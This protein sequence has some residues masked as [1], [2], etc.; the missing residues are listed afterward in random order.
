MS[1]PVKQSRVH[2]VETPEGTVTHID[3]TST[4]A[5]SDILEQ[6]RI[7]CLRPNG[8]VRCQEIANGTATDLLV[9]YTVGSEQGRDSYTLRYTDMTD[10]V[11]VAYVNEFGVA[12]KDCILFTKESVIAHVLGNSAVGWQKNGYPVMMLLIDAAAA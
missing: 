5:V 9:D 7:T 12:V 3:C 6:V 2:T 4:A 10:G 8:I 1:K 11:L